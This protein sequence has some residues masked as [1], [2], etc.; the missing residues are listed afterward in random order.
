MKTLVILC[1]PSGVGKST[2]RELL[3]AR[4]QTVEETAG[5][6]EDFIKSL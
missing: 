1:A 2:I 4:N 5:L 6:I 3:A